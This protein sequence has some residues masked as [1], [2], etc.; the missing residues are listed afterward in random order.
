MDMD[1]TRRRGSH[2]EMIR[3]FEQGDVDILVGTQ[4]VGKGLDFPGVTLVGV[5]LA[6]REMAIPDFRGQERAFQIL[7][8]VA[9]RAGRG[10]RLGEVVFQTFMPEHFA[11]RAAALEDYESFYAAEAEERKALGFP[12]FS[13]LAHLLLDD[14][15]EDRV[16]RRARALQKH[17]LAW[18]GDQRI[19]GVSVLGPAPMVLERLKGRYRWHVTLRSRSA[20]GLKPVIQESL[21]WDRLRRST[22]RLMVDVDPLHSI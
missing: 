4:M 5:L 11:I 3:S 22:V 12:P 21:R 7:T 13:R 17:I 8:Q 9:G 2:R 18:M 10:D 14:P 16:V 19:R 20:K 6:D 15:K 1:T